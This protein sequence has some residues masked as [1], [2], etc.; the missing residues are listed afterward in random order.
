MLLRSEGSNLREYEGTSESGVFLFLDLGD[1]YID[2]SV[3]DNAVT[4]TRI[5]NALDCLLSYV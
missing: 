2:V 1:N 5:K 4:C 3:W